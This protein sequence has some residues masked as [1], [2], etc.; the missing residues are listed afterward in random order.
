MWGCRQHLR[1]QQRIELLYAQ[2][3][4]CPECERLLDSRRFHLHH[5]EYDEE[6]LG[7]EEISDLMLLHALCHERLH[8]RPRVRGL[9]AS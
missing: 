7:A 6:R 8:Q 4:R 3:Y 9:L 1:R 2:S 5:V